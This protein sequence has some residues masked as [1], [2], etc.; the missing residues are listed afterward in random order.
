MI[1]FSKIKSAVK[2]NLFEDKAKN[3]FSKE[4][5][6]SRK[7]IIKMREMQNSIRDLI[8]NEFI[9]SIIDANKKY[10]YSNKMYKDFFILDQTD[11]IDKSVEEVLS[12]E[13][14]SKIKDKIETALSGEIIN[15]EETIFH[16]ENIYKIEGVYLPK[17][18]NNKV[19]GV[20]VFNRAT[21]I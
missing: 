7:N 4:L 13:I 10:K 1:M 3:K 2:E 19:D 15:Y 14:Y 20:L 21:K 17:L 8:G 9:S 6:E 11:I 12:P 5:E 16:K 18:V